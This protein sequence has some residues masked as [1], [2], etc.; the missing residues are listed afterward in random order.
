MARSSHLYSR[1]PFER[2]ML[3][4]QRIRGGGYP[5]CHQLAGEIE[6]AVR[7]IKRDVDFMRNRLKLPIEYDPLRWGYYYSR[8]V[9]HFPSMPMNEA[10]V[11]ALLI[12]DK[13]IAQYHGTPW[14]R[15]LETAFRRL[16]GQLD[17]EASYTLGNLDH[18][19]SFR[20]LAPEDADL[21]MFQ[22]LT[23]AL[24]ERRAIRFEYRNLGSKQWQPRQVHPY[25]LACIDSHW[26]LFAFDTGRKAM[27]TFVLSRMRAV[28]LTRKRFPRPRDFS[29]GE[30]L[31]G[32]FT[33]FKGKDDYEVVV[34][35]DAWATDL[36][37]G[38]RWHASQELTELKDGCSR[39]RFRL[40]SIEEMERFV[41]SFGTHATVI[42]PK[43]LMARVERTARELT[44]RYGD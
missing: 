13:A 38:R 18:A 21:K 14:H 35:F 10:E 30:H 43:E 2:M 9:E 34:E 31:Q 37:R 29:V 22:K 5:N 15:P 16:T 11:F 39:L 4:H 23:Q 33:V 6:V 12:A 1:P 19:F 28:T 8:P 41:L 32:S 24:K 20:P 26:Y 3:I 40:N 7:T 25:H 27:R 44:R 42:R 17:G 36:L